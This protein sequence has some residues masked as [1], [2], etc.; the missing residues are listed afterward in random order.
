MSD[1]SLPP[2]PEPIATDDLR[3]LDET[4]LALVQRTLDDAERTLVAVMAPYERQRRELKARMA[5]VA[6]ERRR[7]ER[8]ARQSNRAAARQRAAAGDIPTLVEALT[9]PPE[10]LALDRPLASLQLRLRTG[11][12]VGLGYPSRPGSLAFT[13]GRQQQN[14]TTWGEAIA[15]WASGWEP[16]TPALLGV[17][18]HLAGT[19]VERVVEGGDVLIDIA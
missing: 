15:L 6:T 14:A 7:R 10:T 12:E 17:R 19:R 8:T 4:G 1:P 5:E 11:G 3:Q 18:V 16:G 9:S 2:L 13:N